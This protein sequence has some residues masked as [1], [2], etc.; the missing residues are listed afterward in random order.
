M[1]VCAKRASLI[2]MSEQRRRDA[3]S[4]FRWSQMVQGSCPGCLLTGRL[5][6]ECSVFLA[7]SWFC[8]L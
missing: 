5:W 2:E 7:E 4:G 1:S 6:A 8:Q 3:G